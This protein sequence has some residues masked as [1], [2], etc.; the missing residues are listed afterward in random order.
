MTSG[1]IV[2]G[3]RKGAAELAAARASVDEVT[4]RMAEIRSGAALLH[5]EDLD[6]RVSDIED[7]LKS[8]PSI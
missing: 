8:L 5:H 1:S 2:S 6:R 4:A 7:R 3:G